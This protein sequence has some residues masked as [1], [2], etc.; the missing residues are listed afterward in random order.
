MTIG[1]RPQRVWSYLAVVLLTVAVPA[2]AHAADT[3][4]IGT[5][6][7][8]ELRIPV[9]SRGTA[10]G[11]AILASVKGVEGLYWNPAGVAFTETKREFT[12]TY[13]DYI[14]GMSVNYLGIT[15]KVG[16]TVSLGLS[17]KVLSV[18]DIVVTTELNP[19][20]TGDVLTPHF[21]TIGV[22]Y[23]QQFTDRVSFGATA[24]LISETVRRV[25]STGLAFDFGF[26]YYTGIKGLSLG[27][28][29]RN[30]G[31]DQRFDGADLDVP[32]ELQDALV[33]A[34]SS[35]SARNF[36]TSLAPAELPTSIEMGLAYDLYTG[37]QGK[38]TFHATFRNN[39]LSTDEYQAGIEF[40]L[41]KT[42]QLRGGYV[43][44]PEGGVQPTGFTKEYIHGATA[45]FGLN[46]PA[47][48]KAFTVDYAYGRTEFFQDNHWLTVGFG[49]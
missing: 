1:F 22:T 48:D 20:G 42:L 21:T 26:Q 12:Y 3:E 8:Q 49:F 13:L 4:R 14:A 37:P 11:G 23:A 41:L 36:R 38:G 18:G 40:T 16:E 9:G 6:A 32:V 19:E 47:G 46:L 5:A 28:A 44:S 39:N 10:L 2:V 31:P 35:A 25:S 27:V 45:G 33:N 24:K 29:I 43:L 15:T 7:A 30:L 34:E 17:A